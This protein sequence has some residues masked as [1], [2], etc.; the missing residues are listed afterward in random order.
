MGNLNTFNR[1]LNIFSRHIDDGDPVSR[2][3]YHELRGGKVDLASRR[4]KDIL[5][6][7]GFCFIRAQE[8]GNRK[9]RGNTEREQSAE[10]AAKRPPVI[11]FPG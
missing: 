3:V 2:R 9:G 1:V 8:Q 10:G 11:P 6:L 7:G 4:L 5:R